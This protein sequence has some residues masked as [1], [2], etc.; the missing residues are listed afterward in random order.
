M[1]EERRIYIGNMRRDSTE[2]VRKDDAFFA[3]G[4]GEMLRI[5]LVIPALYAMYVIRKMPK[6]V[7]HRSLLRKQQKS[8]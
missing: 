7:H 5:R 8:G 4:A 2:K 3:S 6:F 1:A